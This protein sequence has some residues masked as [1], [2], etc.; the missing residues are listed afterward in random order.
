[1]QHLQNISVARHG[2]GFFRAAI[3]SSSDPPAGLYFF[4]K[5]FSLPHNLFPCPTVPMGAAA[6]A[7]AYAAGFYFLSCIC[8]FSCSVSPQNLFS[9]HFFIFFRKTVDIFSLCAIISLV[10]R[11]FSQLKQTIC[12]CGGTGRRARFRF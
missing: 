10:R 4:Q 12:G 6:R 1:M 5:S 3:A 2:I 9:F 7:A 8:S 11:A